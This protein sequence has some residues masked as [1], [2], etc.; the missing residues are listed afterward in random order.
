MTT[1]VDVAVV[2]IGAMGSAAFYELA[3]RGVR[4]LGIEQFQP[5]HDR[6]SSHGESRA[7]R[8]SYF[9]H[10]SYVPLLRRAFT[11]W[12]ALEAECRDTILTVTGILEAGHPGS[13]VVEG[14][15]LASREHDI[16][17]EV[18]DAA[19]VGRRFPAFHLPEDW[20]ALFQPDGG[21][22]RPE[23]AIQAFVAGAR[24]RGA[25]VWTGTRVAAIHPRPAA[26][27]LETDCGPVEAA[28]VIVAA[29][30]W[31]GA[32]AP[33]LAPHLV[34]TRQ[35]LGWFAARDPAL[36]RPERFPVFVL[37]GVK[38]TCYGFPDFAGTGLKAASHRRGR[39]LGSADALRQDADEGDAAQI[40]AGLRL[41]PAVDGPPIRMQT[42]I[43]TRTPDEFFIVDKSALDPRVVLAS[44]CSG[45]GFK[46][47]SVMG[48]ILADL[49]LEGETAHDI[50][51]FS[52]GRFVPAS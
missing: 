50:S 9:E 40:R 36:V 47:A 45:H 33:E 31:I 23:R 48:E 30:P 17:H 43:Y 19:E 14:S 10:P 22:L 41:I 15:I 32:F 2:G 29:G 25:P 24:E 38:D 52:L 46:F 27:T 49:A 12:R 4:V 13:P 21:F 51:R 5:G 39:V 18:L 35:V 8:L 20:R 34:L 1:T 42:C 28:R 11:K 3:A 26:V 37:D 44:P 7:I 16:P 6:G